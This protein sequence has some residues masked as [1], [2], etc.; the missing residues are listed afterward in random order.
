MKPYFFCYRC[1]R[2]MADSGVLLVLV[3]CDF[4]RGVEVVFWLY[5]QCRLRGTGIQPLERGGHI[6]NQSSKERSLVSKLHLPLSSFVAKRNFT[7]EGCIPV[8]LRL[9]RDIISPLFGFYRFILIK[10]ALFARPIPHM[11]I[12]GSI[13]V[14]GE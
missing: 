9:D 11:S 4:G 6:L 10:L 8:P 5:V 12:S 7:T 3:V 2:A 1:K 13:Y 14:S